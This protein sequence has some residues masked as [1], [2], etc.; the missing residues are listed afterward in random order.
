MD[1]IQVNPGDDLCITD[2]QGYGKME[3]C[4]VEANKQRIER[5]REKQEKGYNLHGIK[6]RGL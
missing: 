2:F 1:I 3:L 4:T 5:M 6:I